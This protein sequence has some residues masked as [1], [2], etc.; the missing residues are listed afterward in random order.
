MERVAFKLKIF[1]G[2]EEE[3]KKR[4]DAIWP[5]LAALLKEHGIFDYSIFLEE[6]SGS[7]FAIFKIEDRTRL[8]A[9][10]RHPLM[11]EWWYFMKDIMETNAD[12][13]PVSIPL[14]EVFY[15]S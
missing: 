3:Y 1:K 8:E 13:S 2:M 10:P 9:L 6:T 4:H 5:S 12:H 15:L 11:R 14:K 7:L